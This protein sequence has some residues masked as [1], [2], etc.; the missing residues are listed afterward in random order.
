M[1]GTRALWRLL[2]RVFPRDFVVGA[3]A[4]NRILFY[5]VRRFET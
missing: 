2:S 4:L 1:L 5:V 3:E